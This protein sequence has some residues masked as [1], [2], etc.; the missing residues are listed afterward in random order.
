MTQDE[1]KEY[2]HA[3]VGNRPEGILNDLRTDMRLRHILIHN[4]GIVP[5]GQDEDDF[6]N[7]VL[8]TL[9]SKDSVL[10]CARKP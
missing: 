8:D 7:E 4:S 5:E 10:I 3:I 6:F 9:D 2:F 1:A